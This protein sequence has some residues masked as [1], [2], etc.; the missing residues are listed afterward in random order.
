MHRILP[1]RA[2]KAAG[3]GRNDAP[4]PPNLD[5]THGRPGHLIS[6]RGRGESA[7]RGSVPSKDTESTENTQFRATL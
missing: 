1:R 6:G 3:E 7:I 4:G 5:G 2:Q